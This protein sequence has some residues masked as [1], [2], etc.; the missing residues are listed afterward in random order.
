MQQQRVWEAALAL[1]LL[2]LGLSAWFLSGSLPSGQGPIGPAFFPRILAG[3]LIIG[4]ATLLLSLWQQGGLSLGRVRE[5]HFSAFWRGGAL[6][7][8]LWLTPWLLPKLGLVPTAVLYGMLSTTLLRG[9]WSEVVLLGLVLG[10]LVHLVF[11]ELLGV[12]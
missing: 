7:A 6:W 12:R 4:S 8:A 1:V 10:V 2:F 11:G 5:A 9:R 3:I